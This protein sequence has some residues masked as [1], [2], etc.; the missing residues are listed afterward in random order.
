MQF[1]SWTPGRAPEWGE[2]QLACSRHPRG[3]GYTPLST[4]V[5]IHARTLIPQMAPHF[6]G[7]LAWCWTPETWGGLMP[8]PRADQTLVASERPRGGKG[9]QDPRAAPDGGAPSWVGGAETE[10]LPEGG[11]CEQRWGATAIC[12]EPEQPQMAL[13]G[14]WLCPSLR[15][16]QA[17]SQMLPEAEPSKEVGTLLGCGV[18]NLS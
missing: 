11:R 7:S 6:H 1:R 18:A 3:L 14:S 15:G 13:L 16:P 10:P 9:L 5:F 8:S 12:R 17:G 4:L 2:A